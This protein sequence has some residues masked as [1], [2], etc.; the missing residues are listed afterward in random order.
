MKYLLS[1]GLCSFWCFKKE[2]FYGF[3]ELDV[4]FAH[5]RDKSH[6]GAF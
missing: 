3:E 5:G 6:S 2:S 4:I 1:F